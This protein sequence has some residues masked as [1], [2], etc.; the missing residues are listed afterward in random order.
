MRRQHAEDRAQQ[1]HAERLA[2]ALGV[3]HGGD[4]RA[5]QVDVEPLG[6]ALLEMPLKW[7]TAYRMQLFLYAKAAGAV[8][9]T[10]A[11]N[12]RGAAAS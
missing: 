4:R 2:V 11:D 5:A 10:T 12:W 1:L 9:L 8:D 7:M 3:E 6:R